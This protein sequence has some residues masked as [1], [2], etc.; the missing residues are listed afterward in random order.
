MV[1]TL[2]V[3]QKTMSGES[4]CHGDYHGSGQNTVLVDGFL[5]W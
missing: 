2:A 4:F 5:P 1:I 3:G